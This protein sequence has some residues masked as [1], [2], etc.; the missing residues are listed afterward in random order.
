MAY[1]YADGR[2]QEDAVQV[3]RI[4]T[5][6]SAGGGGGQ[7]PVQL[8]NVTPSVPSGMSAQ[9]KRGVTATLPPPPPPLVSPK[10][11]ADSESASTD[12]TTPLPSPASSPMNSGCDNPSLVMSRKSLSEPSSPRQQLAGEHRV[13]KAMSP[14]PP[15]PPQVVQKKQPLVCPKCR[16][17]A[18]TVPLGYRDPQQLRTL[19]CLCVNMKDGR[20]ACLHVWYPLDPLQQRPTNVSIN[21]V[22][23]E[24]NISYT[25]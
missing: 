19:L 8:G 24:L 5:M 10:G 25:S 16:G 13:V 17:I 7:P 6:G 22:S 4:L 20:K 3:R 21:A 14:P 9:R 12:S 1:T 2:W 15:L 23:S 11:A 18:T